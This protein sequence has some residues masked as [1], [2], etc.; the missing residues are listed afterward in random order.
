MEKSHVIGLDFGSDTVRAILVDA[1]T[2]EQ[3]AEAV[4]PYRRWSE[5]LYCDPRRMQFRQHP[6]DYLES[7]EEVLSLLLD[8]RRD[9]APQVCAI[10]LDFTASTP[11]LADGHLMPLSL[12][13]RYAENPDA[14]F[15]LWKDHTGEREAAEINRA[16]AESAT[17]YSRF[18]GNHYSSECFWSKVLH[19]LRS[20]EGLRRDAHTVVEAC[21]WIPAV[22]TG[23]DDPS[24]A[25]MSHCCA[26][27]KMFWSR[28]WGGFPPR[29]FFE[30]I[31]PVLLPILD[32]LKPDEYTCDKPYGRISPKW[33]SRLGLSTEVT[34]GTGNVDSHQGAIG[35]GVACGR[36]VMN[37]GTSAGVM[38]VMPT[39]A[40]GDRVIDGVFGQVE[41][42]ILPGMVGFEVGLSAFGDIFAWLRRTLSYP[43]TRILARNG[44]LEPQLRERIATETEEGILAC[45]TEDAAALPL[46]EDAPFATDWFNGRR[47]PAPDQSLWGSLMGLRLS[48]SAP[49]LYYALVES[50]AF[51]FRAIFE[52]LERNGIEVDSVTGIGGIS[53]KSP[54]VMQMLAD[55]TGK[56]IEVSSVRQAAALGSAIC[57]SVVGGIYPDIESA[58]H[59]LCRPT[60]RTYYPDASKAAHF[61]RRYAL[62]RAADAFTRSLTGD[63]H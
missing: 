36:A 50:T 44:S 16:C 58:Q 33:A 46:R 8:R 6:K 59:A 43:V 29:E 53:Q 19:L 25:R 12:Q 5:G 28:E 23:N 56:R 18:T 62:Y 26:A 2:G 13:E 45:L 41:S 7:L 38:A 17:N 22:L 32:T 61:E 14:M 55:V 47:S 9:L 37:L 39:R 30:R 24:K 48:T 35:A 63:M 31:D 27:Q 1:A 60:A 3:A 11:C 10:S 4:S 49:E 52:H 40:L 34:I 20:D 57:A 15:V 42:G 54:F 21:D 51:A